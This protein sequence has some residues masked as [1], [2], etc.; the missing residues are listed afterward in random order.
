MSKVN[1]KVYRVEPD[2]PKEATCGICN[3]ATGDVQSTYCGSM[4]DECL[5]KHCEECEVCAKDFR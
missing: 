5:R 1:A 4:C 3:D 2:A